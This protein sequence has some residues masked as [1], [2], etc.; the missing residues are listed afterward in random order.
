MKKIKLLQVD[1]F[2]D[3]PYTGNPAAVIPDARELDDLKMQAIAKEM[4]LSETVFVLPSKK[5]GADLQM[6]WFTP[7]TEVPLCG[8]A[9]IAG[10]H[11]LAEE[12]MYGMGKEGTYSFTLETASGNLPVEVEKTTGGAKILFGLKLPKFERVSHYKLDLLRV[13]N[14]ALS[15][16][17]TRLSMVRDDFLYVPIRRLHTLWNMHPN[18]FAISNFLHGRNL[19]G[20][21]VFT[22]ETVDRDSVV[23]SRFFAPNLGINE[24]PVTGAANG[25]LGVYL[26]ENGI[27][28]GENGIISIKAEQGDVIGRRGRVQVHIEVADGKPI[29]V[30]IGGTAVTVFSGEMVI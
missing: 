12:G 18:F 29:G 6:R 16:F 13:L 1:A 2:T 9:T 27:I 20:L 30:R 28:R 17:E 24:D 8:H 5:P 4:N 7:T 25:P 21:C 3:V 14:L 15:D 22:T 26:F 11:A 19:G 10:F 23:Y